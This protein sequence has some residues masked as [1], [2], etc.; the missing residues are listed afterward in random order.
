[1]SQTYDRQEYKRVLV[2]MTPSIPISH[3]ITKSFVYGRRV[4]FIGQQSGHV[5]NKRIGHKLEG[6]EPSDNMNRDLLY[7]WIKTSY[8]VKTQ[9]QK[10]NCMSS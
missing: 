2:S 7:Q 6:Y 5:I 3:I 4:S 8:K 9:E 10:E 1:M